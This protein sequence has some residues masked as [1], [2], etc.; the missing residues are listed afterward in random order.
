MPVFEL[1]SRSNMNGDQ[2][3]SQLTTSCWPTALKYEGRS[4]R[5]GRSKWTSL[6]RIRRCICGVAVGVLVVLDSYGVFG[7]GGGGEE[8]GA[9]RMGNNSHSRLDCNIM[10]DDQ[11]RQ[12]RRRGE[13][14]TG[15]LALEGA[16]RTVWT[17]LCS[18]G[19]D[20]S[21]MLSECLVAPLT[22]TT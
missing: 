8:E 9:G 5:G 21:L 13:V 19:T 12:A 20:E 2:C 7:G 3:W 15:M 14:R 11:A 4:G 1:P 16:K 10:L 17:V 18:M 22:A 6:H